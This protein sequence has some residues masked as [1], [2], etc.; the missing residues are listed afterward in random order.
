[1]MKRLTQRLKGYGT[2]CWQI[3]KAAIPR[4][5][6]ISFFFSGMAAYAALWWGSKVLADKLMFNTLLF[7]LVITY[8]EVRNLKEWGQ[9]NLSDLIKAAE[10][11]EQACDKLVEKGGNV[12]ING[13]DW[14][15]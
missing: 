10:T 6:K 12:Q 1:M 8:L 13:K 11:A 9:K 5:F 3:V 7:F 2:I 4:A 15:S 14:K